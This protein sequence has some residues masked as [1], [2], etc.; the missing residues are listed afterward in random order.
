VKRLVDE[1]EKGGKAVSF[2]LP[3]ENGG[4]GKGSV[5]DP[6]RDPVVTRHIDEDVQSIDSMDDE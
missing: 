2:N 5:F 3:S 1:A 6:F 4:Y